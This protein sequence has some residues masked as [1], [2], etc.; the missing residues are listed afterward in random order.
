MNIYINQTYGEERALYG[1]S[2]AKIRSCS[3]EG[4]EDGESALKECRRVSITDTSFHLRYPLW[5]AEDAV[6]T[7]STFTETC[8]AGMWYTKHLTMEN[9][10]IYGVKAL[11]EADETKLARCEIISSEFGW[12]CRG[13]EL[14]DT[15]LETEYL[16]LDSERIYIE[17]LDFKGKYS[18]QYVKDVHIK[19]SNLDTKDAF[20]HA[21]NVTVEDSVVSGQYLGWY[22][23]NLRLVRCRI[24]GTQPLCYCEELVLE[25]CTMEGCDLS[26][27][28]SD[29]RASVKGEI[30]S[31]KNPA[32]GIITADSVG[33][34]IFDE[35]GHPEAVKIKI[36]NHEQEIYHAQKE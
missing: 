11:R 32:S 31:I 34:V 25:D 22:S 33:E 14:R 20:W 6:V 8:R 2:D 26:F 36:M 21:E 27:E 16:F 35:F 13:I 9:C 24:S 23:K 30:M 12:K 1:I 29:V 3:F 4:V 7:N 5:H 18:F 15:K 28:K 19:N 17:N 10:R